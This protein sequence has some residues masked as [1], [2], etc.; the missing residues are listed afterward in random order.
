MVTVVVSV[1]ARI[2]VRPD[3][4]LTQRIVILRLVRN[5]EED[6]RFDST[7][8]SRNRLLK[9]KFELGSRQAATTTIVRLRQGVR[10]RSHASSLPDHE[11]SLMKR[12]S[13][14]IEG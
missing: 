9:L 3:E 14:C 12:R 4:G 8:P 1:H 11:K 5:P 13:F 2:A 6:E 7:R 10:W